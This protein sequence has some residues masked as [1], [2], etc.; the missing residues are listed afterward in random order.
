MATD[1]VVRTFGD[2]TVVASVQEEIQMLTAEENTLLN[3]LR[4]A[5]GAQSFTHEWME[6]SLDTPGSAAETE[7][8]SFSAES[9][10]TP[11]RV[12]NLVEHV[13][14]SGSVSEGQQLV[15]HYHNKDEYARQVTK[16]M[17]SWGNSA[18][19]DLLRS[20]QQSGSSGT[21]GQMDGVMNLIST[22]STSHSSGTTFSESI[23]NSLVELT[24]NS[25]NG[26]SA[27]DILVGAKMKRR[28]SNFAG[29]I[30]KNI[31]VT[32]RRSGSVVDAYETDFGTLNVRL[33]RYVQDGDATARVVGMDMDQHRISYLG[34]DQGK[35][36]LKPQGKRSTADDF[37]I[38]GYL[39]LENRIEET[40][41]FSDGFLKQA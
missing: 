37:T 6:D 36:K 18:E 20:S 40:S 19:Y 41:F 22:N 11:T 16:K 29:G 24:W 30:T 3:N 25:G 21:A 9:S 5:S 1:N 7:V 27:T 2:S 33:H 4:E 38:N 10:S 13:Y 32:D 35:A 34:G 39:T 31:D 17:K 12:T 14:K 23:L 15:S 8:K 28:I 26:D